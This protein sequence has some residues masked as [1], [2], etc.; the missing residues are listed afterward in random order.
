[1]KPE[2]PGKLS[3]NAPRIHYKI[4]QQLM[5]KSFLWVNY[6]S[7]NNIFDTFKKILIG[8]GYNDKCNII[9]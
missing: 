3:W 1:M 9:S 7:R 6:L 2:N 5:D 8:I 4:I